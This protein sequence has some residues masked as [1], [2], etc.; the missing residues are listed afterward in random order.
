MLV[1]GDLVE[2]HGW[3][4]LFWGLWGS[5]VFLVWFW[6]VKPWK[7]FLAQDGPIG[8]NPMYPGS[9]WFGFVFGLVA[10]GG[11]GGGGGNFLAFFN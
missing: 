1:F 10:T 7:C 5:F 6:C 8:K 2:F 11:G 3:F 9:F 4:F